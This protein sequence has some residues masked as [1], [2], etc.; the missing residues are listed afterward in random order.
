MT[1]NIYDDDTFF[2]R[3]SQLP[4]SLQG[5]PGSPEWPVVQGLLPGLAGRR[6]LD[7]GCG[8]GW[9]ARWARAQGAAFVLGVDVSAR[10]LA[11]A[12]TE[13]RDDAIAYVRGDLETFAAAPG[14]FELAYSSLAFHYV[15]DLARLFR[16]AHA[17]LVCG[18]KLV[19]SVEHPMLTAATNPAWFVDA[20]GRDTWPV[21]GYLDEGA[22]TSD[23][24]GTRVIKRH[25]TIERYFDLLTDAGFAVSRLI[26]WSP[27]PEQVAANPDWARERER[28][29]FLLI[30]ATAVDRADAG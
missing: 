11:R 26:E 25:R 10:M 24:L 13:E 8:Y 14:V 6:V 17:S 4:R 5:L 15:A 18:G 7:L 22:R 9:F 2:A 28:P 16:A 20:A 30:A 19:F 1:Q 23:W 27:S 21:N 29:F 3:Y 12:R